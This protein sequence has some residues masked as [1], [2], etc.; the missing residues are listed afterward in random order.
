VYGPVRTVVWQG[1]AGDRRPYADHRSVARLTAATA[2]PDLP[3]GSVV[4]LF[5]APSVTDDGP[6]AAKR[7]ESRELP[8]RNLGHPESVWSS[9]SGSALKRT[10]AGAKADRRR[11]CQAESAVAFTLLVI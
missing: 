6:L 1:T 10:T 5:E 4:L 3:V 7:A 11:S 8:Q 2:N 9:G